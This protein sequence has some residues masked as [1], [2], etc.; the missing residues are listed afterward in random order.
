[1]TR[2]KATTILQP[3]IGKTEQ[4]V[5]ESGACFSCAVIDNIDSEGF[6]YHNANGPTTDVP[7]EATLVTLDRKFYWTRFEWVEAIMPISS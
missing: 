3:N 4:I 2:E 5:F 6:V 1:M 7:S